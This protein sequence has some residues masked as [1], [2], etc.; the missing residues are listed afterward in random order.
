MQVQAYYDKENTEKYLELF[1][2]KDLAKLVTDYT[3]G[4]KEYFPLFKTINNIEFYGSQWV[5]E[6]MTAPEW[7]FW[8]EN[9]WGFLHDNDMII[10]EKDDEWMKSYKR[11]LIKYR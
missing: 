8:N 4:P 6:R 9:F 2:I 1:L 7:D 3:L 11:F 10:F 5:Y